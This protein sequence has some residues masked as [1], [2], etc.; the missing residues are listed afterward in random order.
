MKAMKRSSPSRRSRSLTLN[1]NPTLTLKVEL[2]KEVKVLELRHMKKEKQFE[3]LPEESR[4][5]LKLKEEMKTLE[6]QKKKLEKTNNEMTQPG[7]GGIA[8]ETA[9]I[10][11]TLLNESKSAEVLTLNP[12]PNPSS[13]RNVN[14]NAEL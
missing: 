5:V 12:H 7:T 14:P 4:E 8:E 11:E 10:A 1:L 9:D 6:Q 2:L 13:D 3:K